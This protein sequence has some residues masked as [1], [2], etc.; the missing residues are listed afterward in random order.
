MAVDV[1]IMNSALLLLPVVK[2]ATPFFSLR[3]ILTLTGLY[4]LRLRSPLAEPHE[5]RVCHAKIP[6]QKQA[7]LSLRG[8]SREPELIKHWVAR[9]HA[10]AWR[11]DLCGSPATRMAGC[12][13]M[14]APGAI[15]PMALLHGGLAAVPGSCG[16]FTRSMSYPCYCSVCAVGHTSLSTSCSNRVLQNEGLCVP[17]YACLFCMCWSCA[18]RAES[19]HCSG[20]TYLLE[21]LGCVQ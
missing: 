6:I 5:H 12:P 8:R 3:H 18:A 16:G 9:Q 11:S 15:K 14:Q 13:T 7:V 10:A 2:R 17:S 1:V 21:V 20:Q 4:R 19:N